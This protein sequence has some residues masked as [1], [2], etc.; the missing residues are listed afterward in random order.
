MLIDASQFF[1]ISRETIWH[2][3]G[4]RLCTMTLD[5]VPDRYEKHHQKGRLLDECSFFLPVS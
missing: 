4:T 1:F 2:H 5:L 3:T